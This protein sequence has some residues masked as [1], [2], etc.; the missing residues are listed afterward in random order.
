M[1]TN[2]PE[3]PLKYIVLIVLSV[4]GFLLVAFDFIGLKVSTVQIIA[5]AFILFISFAGIAIFYIFGGTPSAVENMDILD[6]AKIIQKTWKEKRNEVISFDETS[7]GTMKTYEA[8]NLT[9]FAINFSIEASTIK[10]TNLL[11]I[12]NDNKKAIIDFTYNPSSSRLSDPFHGF[13][14]IEGRYKEPQK[15][16]DFELSAKFKQP[17]NKIEDI[18]TGDETATE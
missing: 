5:G 15:T 11:V 9:F 8:L 18:S 13:D 7:Q 1:K 14:P 4:V 17:K 10:S 2:F 3:I 16:G 12:W 6:V